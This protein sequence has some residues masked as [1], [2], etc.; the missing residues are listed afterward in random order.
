MRKNK[1]APRIVSKDQT[2]CI[3]CCSYEDWTNFGRHIANNVYHKNELTG[4]FEVVEVTSIASFEQPRN[5]AGI[6]VGEKYDGYV[7]A[8]AENISTV[9][10]NVR[11]FHAANPHIIEVF[12]EMAMFFPTMKRVEKIV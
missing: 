4:D 7:L 11:D 9:L 10:K 8:T 6:E 2:Y 5:L 12:T 3:F 1:R